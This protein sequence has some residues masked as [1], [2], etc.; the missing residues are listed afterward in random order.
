[1]TWNCLVANAF[2][3]QATRARTPKYHSSISVLLLSTDSRRTSARVVANHSSYVAKNL[4]LL[5][6]QKVTLVAYV[7]IVD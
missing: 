2:S 7:R 4:D 5:I 6:V 3:R 1:M